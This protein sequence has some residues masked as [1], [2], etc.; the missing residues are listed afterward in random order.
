MKKEE[1]NNHPNLEQMEMYIEAK[2]AAAR[3]KAGDREGVGKEVK[4]LVK[5]IKEKVF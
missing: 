2:R 4:G 5:Q 3:H 1:K